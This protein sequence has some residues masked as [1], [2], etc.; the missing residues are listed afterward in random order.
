MKLAC[1]DVARAALGEPAKRQSAE[2]FYYAPWR[3]D[4]HASLQINTQKNTWADFPAG[5]SGNG[6][7]LAA[8]F[9]GCDPTDKPAV[10]AWLREHGLQNG[11][12][13]GARRVVETYPYTDENGALLFEAVRFDPKDFA[14]RTGEQR[15]RGLCTTAK[16]TPA[17]QPEEAPEGSGRA[18]VSPF[19]TVEKR[20]V[21]A[22]ALRNL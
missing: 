4:D 10:K 14:Q 21:R 16:N 13:K 15:R 1:A 5:L 6:W 7:E 20:G 17:N 12:S 8:R 3:A 19:I 9:G 2:L 11:N 22:S 18:G